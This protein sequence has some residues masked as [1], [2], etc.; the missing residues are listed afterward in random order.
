VSQRLWAR[1]SAEPCIA[2]AEHGLRPIGD[3]QLTKDVGHIVRHGLAAQVEPLRDLR[4]A[5]A[6]RDQAQ[7]LALALGQLGKG[8][9]EC[10][11]AASPVA[12]YP[13]LDKGCADSAA[14]K[15]TSC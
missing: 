1:G 11:D 12:P 14:E 9:R 4:I 5:L 7:D 15:P 6:L 8:V 2:G 3:L 10:C 13:M